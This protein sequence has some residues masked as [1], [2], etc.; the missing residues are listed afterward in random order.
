MGLIQF[1]SFFLIPKSKNPKSKNPFLPLYMNF[2]AHLY[3][4]GPPSEIMVGNFIAD[5]VRTSML[6][7]FSPDVRKG[8]GLHREIDTFTD[9]HPVVLQSKERLR[10]RYHKYAPVIVD[11]FYDHFLA[12]QWKEYSPIALSA[13]SRDT[14]SFLSGYLNL[15]PPRSLQFYGYMTGN[16]ILT[17]YAS[18][19]GIRRVMRGMSHRASFNSGMETCVEELQEHYEAFNGEFTAFFPDLQSHCAQ[20]LNSGFISS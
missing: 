8:I 5:S 10:V 20:F 9:N 12:V 3:L 6:E 15:F 7:R 19:E 16:D 2:L 11:V 4:S 1:E 18:T 17:A 14:Y 13:W